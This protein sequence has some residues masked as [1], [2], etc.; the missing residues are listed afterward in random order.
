M[1]DRAIEDA[2]RQRMRRGEKHRLGIVGQTQAKRGGAIQTRQ[3]CRS[4]ACLC[5]CVIIWWGISRRV[6]PPLAIQALVL[7]AA[8]SISSPVAAKSYGE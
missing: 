2:Q 4:H 3:P 7:S 8:R 1:L 6:N 5:L